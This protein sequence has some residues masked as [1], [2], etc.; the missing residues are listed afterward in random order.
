MQYLSS[1]TPFSR[2]MLVYRRRHCCQRQ[3]RHRVVSRSNHN[4]N[5]RRQK[6]TIMYMNFE[7]EWEKLTPRKTFWCM[8]YPNFVQDDKSMG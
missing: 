5:L 3:L 8:Y 1:A 2:R 4:F 7:G 6:W